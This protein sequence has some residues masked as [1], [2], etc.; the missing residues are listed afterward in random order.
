[1]LRKE[2]DVELIRH[3]CCLFT[4]WT[5]AFQGALGQPGMAELME[6]FLRGALDRELIEKV[7][8]CDEGLAFG[9]DDPPIKPADRYLTSLNRFSHIHSIHCPGVRP[10]AVVSRSPGAPM[11]RCSNVP[12]SWGFGLWLPSDSF[13][14]RPST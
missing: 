14:G 5:P 2:Q 4:S 11:A 7:K 9:N 1:M 12:V 3:G 8:S 10:S 6:R 13:Q